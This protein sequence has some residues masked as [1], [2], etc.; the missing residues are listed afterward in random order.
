MVPLIAITAFFI[1]G[2]GF[3]AFGK[4]D[5]RIKRLKTDPKSSPKE[6]QEISTSNPLSEQ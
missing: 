6:E 4:D 1:L 3:F 5:F 2:I